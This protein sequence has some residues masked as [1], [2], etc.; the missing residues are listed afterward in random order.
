MI[1]AHCKQDFV[2]LI[3]KWTHILSILKSSSLYA[4]LSVAALV[5][6]FIICAP[7]ILFGCGLWP[8]FSLDAEEI[9]TPC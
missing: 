6:L 8:L 3:A 9:E 4:K 7:E 2:C 5:R 1:E